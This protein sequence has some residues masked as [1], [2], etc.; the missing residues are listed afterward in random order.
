M[1]GKDGKDQA[2][3]GAVTWGTAVYPNS[4][5]FSQ[6]FTHSIPSTGTDTTRPPP[7]TASATLTG[8][9]APLRL[10]PL[11]TAPITVTIQATANV[12]LAKALP[13][14][15]QAQTAPSHNETHPARQ[16]K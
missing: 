9:I 11:D 8:R 10:C 16:Q 1:K 3:G 14:A 12:V 4:P 13:L 7:R 15:A 2:V 5:S 6:P